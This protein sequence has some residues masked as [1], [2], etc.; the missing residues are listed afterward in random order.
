MMN[1]NS[2]STLTVTSKVGI[3]ATGTEKG[4]ADANRDPG[5]ESELEE[6]GPATR[7]TS[8]RP[9]RPFSIRTRSRSCSRMESSCQVVTRSP[10][11]SWRLAT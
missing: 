6:K 10:S 8:R 9:S 2:E 11:G 1:A 3:S 5:G 4:D 7:K